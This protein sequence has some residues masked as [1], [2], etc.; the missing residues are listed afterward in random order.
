MGLG[1]VL[2][3]RAE[4]GKVHPVAYVSCSLSPQERWYAITE[5]ETL[6]VA[7]SVSH[8]LYDRCAGVH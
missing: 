2:Y 8:F 4:D 3:H 7:W 6:A 1:A 5:I